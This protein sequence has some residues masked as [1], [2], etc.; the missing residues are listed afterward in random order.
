MRKIFYF[1]PHLFYITAFISYTTS[2]YAGN[3][4]HKE[5]A[6]KAI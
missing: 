4:F 6:L 3:V 1:L 5:E 2:Y